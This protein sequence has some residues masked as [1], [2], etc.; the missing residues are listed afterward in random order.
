M[1]FALAT[2]AAVV[3]ALAS[4]A[5]TKPFVRVTGEGTV[6]YKP[7][8]MKLTVSVVT[9]G[10]TAQQAADDNATKSTTVINALQKVLGSNGDLQTLGYSVTPNY[11][12]PAGGGQPA[13][14][15]YTCTNSV[16][17]TTPD[18]SSPGR[19][20]DTAI[21]AGATTAGSLTFQLKDPQPARAAAL[22]LATQ[23]A[24]S[25]A[26]AVATGAKGRL[27]AVMSVSESA[28]AV[29]VTTNLAGAT[30]TTTPVETGMVQIHATVILQA[31]LVQ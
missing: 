30:A 6:S 9:I 14:A 5:Q 29:P 10:D 16:E 12:Y 7:D 15:G 25:S 2:L 19:I 3:F 28:A 8:Q 23:Q 22:K 17:V 21:S 20:I 31:E 4:A 1:R 18:L 24:L 26:D 13:I 11:K 27:G